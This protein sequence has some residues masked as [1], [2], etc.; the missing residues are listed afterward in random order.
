LFVG[1]STMAGVGVARQEAALAWRTAVEVSGLLSRPVRWRVIAKTGLKTSQIPALTE[2]EDLLHADVIIT[3]LG[4]ND[5]FGQ[6]KPHRFVEAYA[7]LIDVLMPKDRSR[8]TVVSGLPPLH[9]TPA[10]PQP[11]RWFL[12]I[13]AHELD[14]RLQQWIRT[15]SDVSYISL[16]WAADRTKLAEDRFHPGEG[17]YREWSHRIAHQVALDLGAAQ[18]LSSSDAHSTHAR[19]MRNESS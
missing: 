13:C 11:L 10:I 17:L 14:R 8:R 6:T 9:I 19:V 16:Q 2:R 7:T 15:R 4:A 18:G 3:A 1:D 12:G 5:V